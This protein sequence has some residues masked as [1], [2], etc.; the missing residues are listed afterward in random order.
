MPK[1]AIEKIV[2]KLKVLLA[3]LKEVW[4]YNQAVTKE[5]SKKQISAVSSA[6]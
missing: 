4:Y 2:K 5:D 6:G 3:F 1:T